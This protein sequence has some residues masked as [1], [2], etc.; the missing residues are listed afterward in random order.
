MALKI[1]KDMTDQ[2][3]SK[4]E[5]ELTKDFLDNAHDTERDLTSR[6]QGVAARAGGSGYQFAGYTRL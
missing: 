1:K 3:K 4:L 6:V 5:F 2:E